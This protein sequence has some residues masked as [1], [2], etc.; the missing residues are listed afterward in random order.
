MKTYLEIQVSM[1]KDEAEALLNWLASENY[2][3][4]YKRFI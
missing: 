1:P 4:Y 3:L 2:L